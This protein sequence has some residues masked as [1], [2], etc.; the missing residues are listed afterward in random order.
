MIKISKGL[1]LPIS[2]TPEN[3]LE[4]VD[5]R[6]CGVLG[7]DHVGF[8]PTLKKNIGDEVKA[9]KIKIYTLLAQPLDVLRISI[10]VIKDDY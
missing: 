1:D 4:D 5:V 2:G 3:I 10:E 8:K 7:T 9:K 6:T